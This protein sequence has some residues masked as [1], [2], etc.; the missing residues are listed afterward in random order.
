KSGLPANVLHLRAL[1]FLERGIGRIEVGAGVKHLAVQPERVEVVPHVVVMARVHARGPRGMWP[2][3]PR[4]DRPGETRADTFL[5]NADEVSV[6]LDPPGG[7]ALAEL[8]IGIAGE[9]QKRAAL[10]EDDG[11]CRCCV[12]RRHLG[13]VPEAEADA[14]GAEAPDDSSQEPSVEHACVRANRIPRL[15]GIR[16]RSPGNRSRAHCGPSCREGGIASG[17]YARTARKELADRVG[18]EPT[19]TFRLH[20]ASNRA[21]QTT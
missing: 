4:A 21:P 15:D 12:G 11:A 18:F 20:T 1:R 17:V 3:P 8:E 19:V 5:E 7:V 13:P 2:R 9:V 14:R 10:P 16:G 6:H